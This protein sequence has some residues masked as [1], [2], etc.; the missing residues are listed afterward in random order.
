MISTLLVYILQWFGTTTP[1]C[2]WAIYYI[3][4]IVHNLNQVI[5]YVKNKFF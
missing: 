1:H 5:I 4:A 3:N 2:Y